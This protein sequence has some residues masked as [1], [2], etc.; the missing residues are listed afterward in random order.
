LTNTYPGISGNTSINYIAV[1]GAIGAGKT[2]VA[3]LLAKRLNARLILENFED[4]PYLGKFYENPGEYAFR[5]QIFFL[6]ERYN[7]LQ[8]LNQKELFESYVVCDYIFEKD[9]IFAYMNLN[10][11]DLKVYEQI[12]QNLD[13]NIVPPDLVIYLQT[14]LAKLMDNIRKRNRFVER[15]ITEVYIDNLNDAYNYFFSR[16][17]NS[18]VMIVNCEE[19]DFV[20]SETDFE[21]LLNEIFK[22][23]RSAVEY[24][25]PSL[26]KTAL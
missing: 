8:K 24:Y 13:R 20:N 5:T 17:K 18:R 2:S 7:Q 11:D 4:N 19:A 14:P 9:K 23:D 21:N 10:D 22:S 26:R 12:V 25:N 16:Y 1:E 15:S 6:L 3:S